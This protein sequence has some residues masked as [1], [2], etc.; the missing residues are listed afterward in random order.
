MGPTTF[1][2]QEHER[3]LFAKPQPMLVLS[4]QQFVV[5][6][7]PAQRNKA[8]DVLLDDYGQVKVRFGD[9]EIRTSRKFPKPF[10]LYPGEHAFPV[11][12]MRVVR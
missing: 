5:V 10:P 1:T 7:S 9:R 8:G 6:E 2:R 12:P 3:V 11:M 4:P